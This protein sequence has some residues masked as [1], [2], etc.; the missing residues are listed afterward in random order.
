MLGRRWTESESITESVL[1]EVNKKSSSR[2]IC[3]APPPS[4]SSIA[5]VVLLELL[6]MKV[7][8]W[9]KAQ[10]IWS[11]L[12]VGLPL[13]GWVLL[14]CVLFFVCK[15]HLALTQN[16]LGQ[17]LVP[18][19]NKSPLKLDWE[20]CISWQT[21]WNM[22]FSIDNSEGKNAGTIWSV[23]A[24]KLGT[25]HLFSDS[26]IWCRILWSDILNLTWQKYLRRYFPER[27]SV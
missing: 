7:M 15:K 16:R 5:F 27:S 22:I 13:N 6:L 12:P 18:R 10:T 23:L 1:A 25:W 14:N 20:T 11:S 2:S 19:H 4:Y 17:W 3:S 21:L 9:G 8:W 26:N 24:G